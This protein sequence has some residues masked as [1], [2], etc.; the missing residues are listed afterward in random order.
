[1]CASY[2]M[3]ILPKN[4]SPLS[5]PYTYSFAK[6]NHTSE[7]LIKGSM[8]SLSSRYFLL[9]CQG[10]PAGCW[11][12]CVPLMNA[13]LQKQHRALVME[14]DRR[15]FRISEAGKVEEAPAKHDLWLGLSCPG[16][17]C[18]TWLHPLKNVICNGFFPWLQKTKQN[19]RLHKTRKW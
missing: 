5:S 9:C 8:R 11:R 4:G 19:Q 6:L 7:A 3:Q 17:K 12:L 2:K 18:L 16:I 15:H 10:N 13:H 1:M 14:A